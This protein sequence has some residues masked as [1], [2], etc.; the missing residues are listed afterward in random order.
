MQLVERPWDTWL[1][2][3]PMLVLLVVT[4]AISDFFDA[5]MVVSS[6]PQGRLGGDLQCH[7][8]PLSRYGRMFECTWNRTGNFT[9]NE[10]ICGTLGLSLTILCIILA[11][12]GLFTAFEAALNLLM[13]PPLAAQRIVSGVFGAFEA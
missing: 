7:S 12:C 10:A 4:Y 13:N 9:Q 6:L 1:S 3:G 2:L 5:V 11:G 8:W